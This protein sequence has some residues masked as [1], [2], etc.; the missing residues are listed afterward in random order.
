MLLEDVEVGRAGGGEKGVGEV[1]EV[2]KEERVEEG[3]VG[4]RD[5]EEVWIGGIEKVELDAREGGGGV[6]EVRKEGRRV[7]DNGGIE[8][9][10]GGIE[11]G[12]KKAEE[13]NE[14]VTTTAGA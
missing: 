8:D 7:E 12:R 9:E 3:E 4:K 13:S 1:E 5:R 10:A 14:L 6:G 11:Q 2:G